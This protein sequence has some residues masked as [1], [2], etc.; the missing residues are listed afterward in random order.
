MPDDAKASEVL[1]TTIT[2]RV[3]SRAG[4]FARGTM[5]ARSVAAPMLNTLKEPAFVAS[6]HISPLADTRTGLVTGDAALEAT[7]EPGL[8]APGDA[9][10]VGIGGTV[11]ARPGQYAAQL[12]L[13]GETGPVAVTPLRVE[14]A[15]STAW[16]I[17]C[18]LLGLLLL[19]VLKLLTGE[20]DIQ[21]RARAV[22]R[23]RAEIHGSWQ[24]TPPPTSRAEAVA[25]IDRDFDD[26]TRA[27][28]AP[29]PLWVVD[30]RLEDAE[31]ARAAAM[32][33]AA[34]LRETMDKEPSIN[35][36]VADL[37]RDW[38]AFRLLITKLTASDPL[39]ATPPD[40]LVAHA[41]AL[42]GQARAQL[43]E[44][45][46][47]F[48]SS[49]IG[50]QVDRV[51]LA[52]ASG[53]V[54]RAREMAKATRVWMRRASNELEKRLTLTLSLALRGDT[55][56]L[57]ELSLRRLATGEMLPPEQRADLL[58]RL[59]LAGAAL[60]NGGSLQTFADSSRIISATETQALRD[61]A[62][63]IVSSV[64]LAVRAAADELSTIAVDSEFQKLGAPENLT[65]DQRAA[66]VVAALTAWRGLLGVVHDDVARTRMQAALDTGIAAGEK[67]DL[68]GAAAGYHA[69]QREWDAYRP[70]HI[71]LAAVA[72][73]APICRGWRAG[74]LL[75]LALTQSEVKLQSGRPEVS[76]WDRRL[77]S[78]RRSLQAVVPETVTCISSIQDASRD[79]IRVSQ[80][81]FEQ[82]LKD[83]PVPLQ[84]RLDAAEN[85]G[86]AAAVSMVQTLMT[87]PRDM[88]LALRTA[89]ADQITGQPIV[90]GFDGLDPEWGP[91]VAITVDWKDGTTTRTTGERL[92]QGDR[93]E[94]VY[95]TI[96]TVHPI[97]TAIDGQATIGESQTDVY[98]KPSPATRAE[99]LA[100]IFLTAQFGLALLIASVVYYWRFHL[101]AIVFGSSSRHY[102]NAFALGFAAYA[103]VAELPKVLA[104]LPF[105]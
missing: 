77:D 93:L 1:P 48:A 62:D 76:G 100:D 49:D 15:A 6:A 58:A 79:A 22:A 51:T 42:L 30:R 91:S 11:P 23:E 37:D 25:E 24:R 16:G 72:T 14:V 53:D 102:V 90:L 63:V 12:D 85:S 19:G 59:N 26:A 52:Q 61:Q 95:R 43:L 84:T 44:L 89:E 60:S 47:R 92:H 55:M 68:E 18:M 82:A 5:S 81:V 99:Q 54:A 27:L 64:K 71:A 2:L 96:G 86:V 13:R 56:A 38:T 50:A 31:A 46:A 39:S 57:S 105:K 28:A 74:A 104:E 9:T 94:H 10:L 66:G 33:A 35:G 65:R 87:A 70:H 83:S 4:P 97:A 20:G 98:V 8:L 32:A 29:R 34:R 73:I 75:S 69:M 3:T 40:A 45:P 41:I 36:E 21:D 7:V 101:D 67:L 88:Q 103:A 78:A 17:A 80:E